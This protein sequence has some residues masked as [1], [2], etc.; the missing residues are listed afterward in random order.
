MVSTAVVTA[1]VSFTNNITFLH[2]LK[3][4]GLVRQIISI[5]HTKALSV[6]PMNISLKHSL[7]EPEFKSK[8]HEDPPLFLL[9]PGY[10]SWKYLSVE[11]C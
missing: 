6:F 7:A 10:H 5:L 8:S 3:S 11:T 4:H 2:Y 1:V 9:D